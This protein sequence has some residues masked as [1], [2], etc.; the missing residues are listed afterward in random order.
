M[1]IIEKYKSL[2]P[3]IV[4][5][6]FVFIGI[7]EKFGIENPNSILAK[8]EFDFKGYVY[9]F[10]N[11]KYDK[12][13]HLEADI[14]KEGSRYYVQRIYFYNGGYIDFDYDEEL[15]ISKGGKMTCGYYENENKEWCFRFY[16]DLVK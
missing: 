5:F 13:Y 10:P 14:L 11:E 4:I 6:L 1:K 3:I 15:S 7:I 16:G 2:L 9:A 12:N 8:R